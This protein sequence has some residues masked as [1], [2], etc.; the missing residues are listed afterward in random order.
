M[1]IKT[2]KPTLNINIYTIFIFYVIDILSFTFIILCV[3]YRFM[4]PG[5]IIALGGGLYYYITLCVIVIYN[6]VCPL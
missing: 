3:A 1:K 6:P 2:P 5:V 4:E